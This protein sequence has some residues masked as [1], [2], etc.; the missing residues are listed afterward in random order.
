MG[1]CCHFYP[2]GPDH[3]QFIIH[4]FFDHVGK[5]KLCQ[6]PNGQNNKNEKKRNEI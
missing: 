4:I 2:H 5:T 6:N 1:I 3:K